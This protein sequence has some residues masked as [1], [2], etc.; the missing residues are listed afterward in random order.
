VELA[1]RGD[2][3]ISWT[4]DVHMLSYCVA[5]GKLAVRPQDSDNVE[6]A[7]GD[8]VESEHSLT[9]RRTRLSSSRATAGTQTGN[10]SIR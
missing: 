6:A 3:E 7:C 9:A 8:A 5:Q 10:E 4:A 2:L 1:G